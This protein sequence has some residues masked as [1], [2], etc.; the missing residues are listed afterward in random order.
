M[1]SKF[2]LGRKVGMSEIIGEDG[3]V[4][5]VTLISV[6]PLHII[7]VKSKDKNGY[8]AI[9]V[10][11]ETM[12]ESKA[13]SPVRGAFKKAGIEPCRTVREFRVDSTDSFKAGDV[14]NVDVFQK[15]DRVDVRGKTIGRG[16]SGTIRRW[17]FSRGPMSHG[18]KSHRIPGSIGAGTFPGH[19]IKGKKMAGHYGDEFVTI[20]NLI[21]MDV[22]AEKGLLAIRGSFPG[23]AGGLVR[24]LGK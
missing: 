6:K 11:T 18:S 14:L 16:F 22:N 12:P 20:K 15:N 4:A 19:V 2:L 21:V 7:E 5:P 13:S 3:V 1:S 24:I 17:N 8:T 23:K 9:K 10:A